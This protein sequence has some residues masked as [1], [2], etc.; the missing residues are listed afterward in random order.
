MHKY[1]NLISDYTMMEEVILFLIPLSLIHLFRPKTKFALGTCY[2]FSHFIMPFI[3]VS[4]LKPYVFEVVFSSI[5]FMMLPASLQLLSK[6]TIDEPKQNIQLVNGQK[7]ITRQL[8]N[9]SDLFYKIAMSFTT[10]QTDHNVLSY[11][12]KIQ[13]NLCQ[14]CLNADTCFNKQKGDHRLIKLLK[15]GIIEGLSKEEQHYVECYCLHMAQYKK[16]MHEQHKLYHHQKEMNDQYQVLKHHLYDQLSLVGQML[17]NYAKNIEW[18]DMQSVEYL[19]EL[20]EAY[21][22]KVWYIRKDPL[23][24]QTFRLELGMTEVTKKEVN[25][26]II[27]ILEKVL[28]S[29]LCILKHD[30]N[31]SQLGYTQLILSNHFHYELVYSIHQISKEKACCGDSYLAFQY[32]SHLL[33]ALSDGMGYGQ[34]AHEESELT[35]DVFSR[36]LKSGIPLEDCI[37]TINALLRI[38]NR[39]DMFT[40]LDVLMFDTSIGEATFIKNGAMPSYIY[41]NNELIPIMPDTLPIG[42]VDELQVYKKTIPLEEEDYILMCS[43]GFDKG[44]E[45]VAKRILNQYASQIPQI[46]VDEILREMLEGGLVDDDATIIVL[47][48]RKI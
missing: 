40:T 26:V 31:A 37:Q 46:I 13:N 48:M 27:P 21:H 45:D 11:V 10:I 30:N 18:K 25:E 23:S 8:E 38:K 42:I 43:D 41:R 47:K 12:G 36:L 6:K 17:K 34:K 20:L 32:R 16:L 1:F 29:E 35:L 15:K 22:Y 28:D 5:S 44:F 9:Y 2:V 3:S 24:M 19:K 33:V 4:S 7:K 39:V 14:H